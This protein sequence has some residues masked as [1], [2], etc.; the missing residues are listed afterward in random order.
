MSP[1][2]TALGTPLGIGA[3]DTCMKDNMLERSVRAVEQEDGL[4]RSNKKVRT[5][6]IESNMGSVDI[7]METLVY[8]QGINQEQI[9]M[10]SSKIAMAVDSAPRSSFRDSLLRIQAADLNGV[11]YEEDVSDDEDQSEEGDVECPVIH[12]S[13][14]EKLLL[15]RPWRQALII[16]VMGRTMG[17]TYLLK[18]ITA[19]WRPKSHVEMIAIPGDYF[20]VRSSSLKDYNFAKFEGPWMILDHYLI[21]KEWYPNFDPTTDRTEKMLVWVRFPCLSIEY[22]NT[23][24]LMKVAQHI[25]RLVKVDHA[26][27]FVN[28]GMFARVCVEV[29]LNK[30]FVSKFMIQRRVRKVEYEGVHMVCFGCGM[31][32]HRKENYPFIQANLIE[33][34]AAPLVVNNEGTTVVNNKRGDNVEVMGEMHRADGG[35]MNLDINPEVVGRFG[36]WMLVTRKAKGFDRK[37]VHWT[38][39]NVKQDPKA[40][41]TTIKNNKEINAGAR[42]NRETGHT[43][44]KDKVGQTVLQALGILCDEEE[45]LDHIEEGIEEHGREAQVAGVKPKGK[46]KR[47]DVQITEKE[48]ANGETKAKAT[49][50]AQASSSVVHVGL[51]VPV[52]QRSSRQAAAALEHVVVKGTQNGKVVTREVVQHKESYLDTSLL[53]KGVTSEHFHDPPNDDGKAIDKGDREKSNVEMSVEVLPPRDNRSIEGRDA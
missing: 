48:V 2:G 33:K 6:V 29:D 42:N 43:R 50:V 13:R 37:R 17:Y 12:V 45:R 22:Y 40:V 31:Y 21:V 23:D 14:E 44:V 5:D 1:G 9:G 30:P 15:R 36:S 4:Q 8:A 32:G 20:L 47:F 19:L 38:M 10:D 34:S 3:V 25:G 7:V 16:K 18:R 28:R 49:G 26:T 24:F 27:T 35:V 53:E 11:P 39:N 52:V 51:K 41:S 46:G